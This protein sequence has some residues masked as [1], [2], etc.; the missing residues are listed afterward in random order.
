MPRYIG[1]RRGEMYYMCDG[2]WHHCRD[3]GRCFNT[4]EDAKR[5]FDNVCP[6]YGGAG[7]GALFIF[8]IG[9]LFLKLAAVII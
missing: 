4:L 9:V 5:D 8:L 7:C 3:N 6:S 1:E 2:K